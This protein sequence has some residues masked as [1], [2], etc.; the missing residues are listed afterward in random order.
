MHGD[1][2]VIQCAPTY[3]Y[4]TAP[5]EQQQV[6][7]APGIRHALGGS[8]STQVYGSCFQSSSAPPRFALRTVA[9]P[10]LSVFG[11]NSG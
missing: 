8:E 6:A 9:V 1:V 10:M 2:T 7:V 5:P 4:E 3:P 11:Q